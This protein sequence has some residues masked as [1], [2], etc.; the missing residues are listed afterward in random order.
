LGTDPNIY[1]VCSKLQIP[2]MEEAKSWK[3][4]VL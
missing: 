4:S 2:R 1:D 3:A